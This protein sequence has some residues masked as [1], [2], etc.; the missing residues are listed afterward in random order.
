MRS[1]SVDLCARARIGHK[2]SA[3]DGVQGLAG[4]SRDE[5]IPIKIL[6]I[7]FNMLCA[8]D[9][10]RLSAARNKYQPIKSTSFT[11]P[12]PKPD[13]DHSLIRPYHPHPLPQN[14]LPGTLLPAQ[15]TSV[16]LAAIQRSR[17][18]PMVHRGQLAGPES[19]DGGY[20]S[21]FGFGEGEG[22]LWGCLGA[23]GGCRMSCSQVDNSSANISEIY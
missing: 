3:S 5:E 17:P 20:C 12:K 19:E 6:L 14:L 10:R 16:A 8:S 1:S 2:Y 9:P 4:N 11:N 22:G 18:D 15:R 7:I 21:E 13:P 23:R